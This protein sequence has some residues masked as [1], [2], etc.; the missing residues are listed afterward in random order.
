MRS[1]KTGL[2]VCWVKIMEN[3]GAVQR[4]TVFTAPD[5]LGP[6]TMVRTG[7]QPLGMNAGDFDLVVDPHDGKAY[8]Y[9]ERVHSELI[10][11]DLT[12]DCT[13]VTGHYSTHF[14]LG[15]PPFVREAPAH[16]RR[17]DR[18]YLLTSG[19]SGYH[20]N[21]SEVA[22]AT[23]HH[24]PW[25]VLGNPHPDDA[26]LTSYNS[27]I[28]SVFRHP[29]KQDLYIALADRWLPGLPDAAGPTFAT[30][31]YSQ[32][33]QAAWARVFDPDAPEPEAATEIPAAVGAL[34]GSPD[35][36]IADYV[37]LPITFET[38]M[39]TL[40]WRDEWRVDEFD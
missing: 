4:S 34:L 37:W 12:D 3:A 5:I 39:P 35:T 28:S 14:P 40:R 6:Y 25:T 20:P 26:S 11:A 13:D 33:V 30:G 18:H 24:G 38:G 29:A 1:P 32:A 7:L 8:Y 2:Y 36:S 16:F 21:P 23:D 10:C 19:T 15:S 22:T 9:F 31:A 27:Q 17:D